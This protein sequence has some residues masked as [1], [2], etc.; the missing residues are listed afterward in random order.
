MA[1]A[2]FFFDVTSTFLG[3]ERRILAPSVRAELT[4]TF[5]VSP[6]SPGLPDATT[7]A[8]FDLHHRAAVL[9]AP[10]QVSKCVCKTESRGCMYHAIS[11]LK[12]DTGSRRYNVNMGS[13][14]LATTSIG[15]VIFLEKRFA[16]LCALPADATHS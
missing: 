15:F 14:H 9:V 6:E 13:A 7:Q 12:A 1:K 3:L 4:K 10:I 5:D 2:I 8:V 16:F 11:M